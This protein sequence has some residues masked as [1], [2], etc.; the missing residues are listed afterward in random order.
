MT[1]EKKCFISP[2]DILA[3]RFRC[4]KCSAT[5]SIPIEKLAS[6]NLQKVLSDNCPH[7]GTESNFPYGTTEFEKFIEFNT[8]LGR[9]REKLNGRNLEYGFEIACPNDGD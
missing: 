5:K 6:A 2:T 9:L 1:F 7:C 3:V 8:L 4:T